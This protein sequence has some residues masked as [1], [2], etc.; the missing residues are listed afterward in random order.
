MK[1]RAERLA[2][3]LTILFISSAVGCAKRPSVPSAEVVSADTAS[4][5]AEPS[6]SPVPVLTVAY[7]RGLDLISSETVPYGAVPANVPSVDG[8]RLLGW[9][10]AEGHPMDPSSEPV[11]ADM[12][13]YAITRPLLNEDAPFLFPDDHGFLLPNADFTYSDAAAAPRSLLTDTAE[14]R[15]LL[16]RYD[17][18]P[19]EPMSIDELRAMLS[20]LF[21]P[22]QAEEVSAELSEHTGEL[23]RADAAWCYSR[24][25]EKPLDT[26]N[27]YPDLSPAHWAFRELSAISAPGTL[28][29]DTLMNQTLDSF[30]W[31][32]GYLY[33]LD[34]EGYFITDKTAD[35]LY[36]GV[37]GRYSSGDE[38]LDNYVA[39]TLSGYM[40]PGRTRRDLLRAAYLH[41]KNDF[42]YLVRNYY[43]S[44]ETGWAIPE[45]ITMYETGKGNC[46]NYAGVFWSLARG[47]GYNAVTYSGT[48]GNQNQPHAWTEITLDG[49]I[50]ICDPE[51]EMNY[52]WLA[53]LNNDNSMYT[54]NFMMPR[55]S[56]GNWNYQAVG[57]Q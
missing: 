20:A 3:F 6:P 18:A 9:T 29:R 4:Y 26:E 5:S 52:W 55:R 19:G 47:L 49:E 32:D 8:A 1:A 22:E 51:I 25:T 12:A 53:A 36:F 41:V 38:T 2:L 11:R 21:L 16:D 39:Q 28:D 31:F 46:Y 44:G 43:A 50:Y 13:L 34:G 23:T 24:L 17:A 33:R 7:Y 57:R 42:N 48:M 14:C 30:L 56:A 37:N 27:Y 45:A 40:E 15:E 10:D 54:D 35:D